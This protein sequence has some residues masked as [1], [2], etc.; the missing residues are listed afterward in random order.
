MADASPGLFPFL[1]FPPSVPNQ[2]LY[3]KDQL[4]L[5]CASA[6]SVG[7]G[8]AI[9]APPLRQGAILASLR[10]TEVKYERTRPARIIQC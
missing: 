2:R 6:A 5:A 10:E 1:I 7:K 9:L 8:G 3:Q 4:P